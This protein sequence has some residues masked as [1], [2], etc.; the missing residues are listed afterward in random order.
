MSD[1][2]LVLPSRPEIQNQKLPIAPRS[3]LLTFVV[4]PRS[5]TSKPRDDAS[6]L[7]RYRAASMWTVRSIHRDLKPKTEQ[8][9][10]YDRNT[11]R[12][13]D[14]RKLRVGATCVTITIQTCR[15]LP[16]PCLVRI[17]YVDS[18]QA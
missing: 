15:V 7:F 4:P 10:C 5:E 9:G 6:M 1:S 8:L 18:S 14:K 12:L 3:K 2:R 13:Y 16:V 11:A 17:S